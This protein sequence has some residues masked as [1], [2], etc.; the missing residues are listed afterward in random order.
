MKFETGPSFDADY[1]RLP[2]EHRRMFSARLRDF[3][4]GCDAWQENGPHPHPW[5]GNLRVHMLSNT[6]IWST[7]WHF[8]RPDGR[9][10]FQFIETNGVTKVF[11]RRIGGHEIYADE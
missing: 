6:E 1:K 2:L 4:G 10:T 7:T 3:S 11:W 8:R 5:P 9:A